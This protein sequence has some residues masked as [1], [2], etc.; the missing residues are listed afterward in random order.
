MLP[1]VPRLLQLPRGLHFDHG[2]RHQRR[3]LR[4]L[5]RGMRRLQLVP[6]WLHAAFGRGH[7]RHVVRE[8][9]R[10]VPDPEL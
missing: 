7:R 10:R 9:P 3:Q 1:V 8:L 6:R 4:H 5:P 2:R